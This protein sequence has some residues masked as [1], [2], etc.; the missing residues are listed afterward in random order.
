M[1]SNSAPDKVAVVTGA[2]SG[3]GR[4]GS[5]R[6]APSSAGWMKQGFLRTFPS[7]SPGIHS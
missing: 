1:T 6:R 3:I 2:S 4:R 5:R 7:C